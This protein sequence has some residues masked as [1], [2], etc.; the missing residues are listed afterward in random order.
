MSEAVIGIL[1]GAISG[2]ELLA[3][4]KTWRSLVMMTTE[5]K[6]LM[7]MALVLVQATFRSGPAINP[8]MVTFQLSLVLSIMSLTNIREAFSSLVGARAAPN[9]MQEHRRVS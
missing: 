4:K 5:F 2:I 1:E 9:S 3:I 6:P 7:H 8:G